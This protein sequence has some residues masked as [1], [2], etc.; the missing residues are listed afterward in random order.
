M[1][2]FVEV[3]RHSKFV[4]V[5]HWGIVI[6]CLF[7]TLTGIQLAFGVKIIDD[8][9]ALHI[10]LGFIFLGLWLLFSYFVLTEEWKW[11]SPRRLPYSI[12]FVIEEAIAW[13]K[14]GHVDD[15]RAYDP[16]RRE[17]VEKLIP[18]QVLVF[19]AYVILTVV[20]ALTGLALYDYE[21]FRIFADVSEPIANM[22]G[23][24]S[25][26]FLRGLHRFAMYLYATLAVT[27][28]YAA[29]IFGTLGSMIHGKRKEK[30]T[31][32]SSERHVP[33][34]AGAGGR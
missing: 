12:R 13:I 14:G 8:A 25:Y 31:T 15:P 21:K 10:R 30:V 4:R 24:T 23:V 19:W 16:R 17:Y 11:V 28:A 9:Q 34:I 7:L 5:C 32:E 1:K 26:A 22:F 33:A 3:E 18:S 27:H 6:T 29:T 2:E 20:V